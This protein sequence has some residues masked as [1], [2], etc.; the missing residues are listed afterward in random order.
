MPDNGVVL[1]NR[2]LK[3]V[4]RLTDNGFFV[5]LKELSSDFDNQNRGEIH[6]SPP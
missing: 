6:H 3:S 2:L 5:I 1:P 4:I